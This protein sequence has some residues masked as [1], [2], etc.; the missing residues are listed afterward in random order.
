M[1]LARQLQPLR[2]YYNMHL[3][4]SRFGGDIVWQSHQAMAC[5]AAGQDVTPPQRLRGSGPSVQSG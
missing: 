5:V 4:R 1:H 3:A 2:S